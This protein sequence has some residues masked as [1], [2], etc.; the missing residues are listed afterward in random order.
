VVERVG[1]VGRVVGLVTDIYW[2]WN[3]VVGRVVVVE[4]VVVFVV[5]FGR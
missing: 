1:A 2:F 3:L 4:R 5:E